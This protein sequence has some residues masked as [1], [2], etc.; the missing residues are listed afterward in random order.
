MDHSAERAQFYVAF[1]NAAPSAGFSSGN[2]T[3]R[4]PTPDGGQ[5]VIAARFFHPAAALRECEAHRIAL[6]PPQFYLVS[7]LAS[8]LDGNVNTL[9]QR[10][11]VEALS[12]GVFGR[13]VINPRP[14]AHGAPDGWSILTYEGDETR[15]GA[16]GRLHRSLVK[17]AGRGTVSEVVLQRNFD[18]FSEIEEHLFQPAPKL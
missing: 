6:M 1:L 14:L 2:K 4:L 8:I 16:K 11:R 13:M 3:E 15:G 9:E 12:S 10:A 7:T 17:F 5:E 18:V